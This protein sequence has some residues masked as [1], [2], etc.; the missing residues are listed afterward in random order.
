MPRPLSQ[1]TNYVKG[2]TEISAADLNSIIAFIKTVS[3]MTVDPP[4]QAQISEG[5]F[6]IGFQD[7]TLRLF[8]GVIV[9]EGPS[10]EADYTDERYWWKRQYCSN[11]TGADTTQLEFTTFDSGE[12]AYVHATATNLAEFIGGS[13][14]LLPD[15]PVLIFEVFDEQALPV[16]R[17]FFYSGGNIG[18]HEIPLVIPPVIAN[19]D[20]EAAQIDTGWDVEDQDPNDGAEIIFQTRSAFESGGDDTLYAFYRTFTIDSVGNVVLISG[21]TRDDVGIS[22]G[23]GAHNVLDGVI[24][25]DT[26]T[27]SPFKGGLIVGNSSPV[28]WDQLVV[29]A[30]GV[31]VVDSAE[32]L[33]LK[34]LPSSDEFKVLQSSSGTV[35][36]FDWVRAH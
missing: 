8:H 25:S 3:N 9:D 12:E 21:E 17:Y 26:E 2:M 6:H 13:H 23:G 15:A 27:A 1:L 10:A 33:G 16:K 19:I 11:T 7:T 14:R 29:G 31:L 34:W 5:G 28:K 20:I 32:T 35:P 22:G 4:L 30:G 18:T 36:V 24:H